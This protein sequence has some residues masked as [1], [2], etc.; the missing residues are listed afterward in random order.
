[1][2][3]TIGI[4]NESTGNWSPY[5]RFQTYEEADAAYDSICDLYPNSWVEILDGALANEAVSL[6]MP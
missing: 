4:F 2:K 3:V 6:Y 5:A 1:M